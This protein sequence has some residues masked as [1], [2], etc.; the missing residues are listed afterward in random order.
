MIKDKEP[1]SP[2]RKI[3]GMTY[4]Y[5]YLTDREL[6][7]FFVVRFD[8]TCTLRY[9]LNVIIIKGNNHITKNHNESVQTS[10]EMAW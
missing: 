2:G 5:R 6:S 7:L 1:L 10:H 8:P 3:M 9:I 4:F